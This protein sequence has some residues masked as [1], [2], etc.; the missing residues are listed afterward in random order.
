M[1]DELTEDQQTEHDQLVAQRETLA[2]K[3][4]TERARLD[5]QAEREKL[6]GEVEQ[7]EKD[8]KQG[9][10]RKTEA[11]EPHADDVP[12]ERT[13]QNRIPHRFRRRGS[14]KFFAGTVGGV[15]AD[16]RAYRFGMFALAQLSIQ[17]PARYRSR[18]AVEFYE[19]E[20]GAAHQSNDANGT[21]VWI[22]E[23]FGTDLIDL[24]ERF[25]LVRRLFRRVPMTSDTR[26]DPR[27]EQG[28]TAYFFTEGQAGTVSNLK[29]DQVRLTAKDLMVLTT[30][31]NN[32]DADSPMSWGD[33]LFGE[34]SYAMAHKEDLCGLLGDATSTYGGILGVT[35]RLQSF[36][37]AGTD[38]FGLVT[39]SGNAYSELT[40]ANFDAVVGKLPEFGDTPMT[41][42]VMHRTFY[43]G[44]VEKLVQA[45]GGVPAY[46]VREGNRRPRPVFKGYPVEFSQVMPKTEANSQVCA[47]LGDF[48]LGAS[49]GDRQQE[50]LAFSEDATVAGQN[51]FE[52]NEVAVRGIER[53]DINVHSVGNATDAGAIV[54]LQTAAS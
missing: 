26:T 36:D 35:T 1:H 33:R 34:I 32:V 11:D 10:G 40:L 50:S 29:H 52:R 21:S 20:W 5:R 38:S 27:H 49:F 19:K 7:R 47:L 22:P 4:T 53:F 13:S 46:E 28:L 18:E 37:G 44:T 25:G 30:I 9:T 54:G 8:L 45:S 12:G 17:M 39:G 41:A 6:A 43:F 15:D 3:I 24:R 51:V 14:L 48:D 16:E 23:E 2:G 42:W 31:N